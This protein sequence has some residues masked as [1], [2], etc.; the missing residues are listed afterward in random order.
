MFSLQGHC[1][2]SYSKQFFQ[3]SS[4]GIYVLTI[5]PPDNTS[6]EMSSFT[7]RAF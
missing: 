5:W 4:P 6:R 2:A 3:Q 1:S 7:E